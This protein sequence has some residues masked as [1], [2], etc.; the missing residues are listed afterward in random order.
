MT[1]MEDDAFSHALAESGLRYI[2]ILAAASGRKVAWSTMLHA[3]AIIMES[4]KLRALE[5]GAPQAIVTQILACSEQC[6]RDVM[7]VAAVERTTDE[8]KRPAK[9]LLEEMIRGMVGATFE[10][11]VIPA[12]AFQTD[13]P[14]DPILH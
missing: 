6:A 10:V 4:V 7:K 12:S 1:K 8:A 3:A 11:H 5:L 13:P 14:K 2:E 9:E